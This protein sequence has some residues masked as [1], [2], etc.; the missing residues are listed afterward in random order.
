[1]RMERRRLQGMKLIR[2]PLAAFMSIWLSGLVF[3]LCCTTL[4]AK[5]PAH[6]PLEKSGHCKKGAS[7]PQFSEA[8]HGSMDC[9]SF[10]PVLFDKARK[11]ETSERAATPAIA[12]A[13]VPARRIFVF[14]TARIEPIVFR[15]VG[16]PPA[17]LFIRN[18]VFRI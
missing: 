15:D 11:V 2:K 5:A 8:S 4:N 3:L 13:I 7:A 14:S 12:E 6:C 18:R 16:K 17:K 9:C 1:M 10:L